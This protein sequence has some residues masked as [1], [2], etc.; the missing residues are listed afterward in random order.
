GSFQPTRKAIQITRLKSGP[1]GNSLTGDIL[2]ANGGQAG[3]ASWP[4]V[5]RPGGQGKT[6]ASTNPRA[7]L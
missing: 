1:D 7:A 2:L 6:V 5:E 3:P 4:V